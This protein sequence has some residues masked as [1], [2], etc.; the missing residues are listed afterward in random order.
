MKFFPYGN[1][2][3]LNVLQNSFADESLDRV[4]TRYLEL[5]QIWGSFGGIICVRYK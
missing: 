5:N 2:I 1:Y 3:T 4:V